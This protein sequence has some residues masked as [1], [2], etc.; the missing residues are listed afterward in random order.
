[1]RGA[2]YPA[3][4]DGD[5]LASEIPLP[6]LDEQR[7]I[8]ARIEELFA[9]IE[10]ARRLRAAA[11]QDAERLMD[12]ALSVCFQQAQRRAAGIAPLGSV[13]N[14][15]MGQSPPGDSYHDKPTGL[16]LLNG[17]TEFGIEYPTPVQWTT[18]PTKV[19]E[20]GDLLICVRGAT[21]GRTNWADQ[22]YCIGRGIAA[23]RS[24][25]DE[26]L[27]DYVAHYIRAQADRI[28][29]A[30]RGSTFPNFT[31]AQL[32]NWKLPLLP[33]PE[34][35]RIVEYL[36]GV[37]AQVSE[38]KRLQAESAAELERLSGAVLAR[39]LRGEL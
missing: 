1:M 14:V 21:T 20:P 11:D 24:R 36:D 2:S 16:P 34:Q 19:C 31:K 22:T 10:E 26:I 5:V 32:T 23:I 12:A 6:P 13:C 27:L 28:L 8:V 9:R 30:G 17:P 38:L 37:Q 39:A 4:T 7:R 33:L 18:A 3:V 25:H 35:H 29:A 15:V